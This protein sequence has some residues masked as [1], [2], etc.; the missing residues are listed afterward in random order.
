L[1][2][3]SFF[4]ECLLDSRHYTKFGMTSPKKKAHI[5][6]RAVTDYIGICFDGEHL[7]FV[8]NELKGTNRVTNLR[9]LDEYSASELAL[10][11][12]KDNRI[13]LTPQNVV[14]DFGPY[15]K[16][17]SL[18]L[19]ALWEDL[20]IALAKKIS[21]VDM[22][23]SEWNSL[24]EQSTSLGE[25]GQS[26]LNIYLTAIGLPPNVDSTRF[27]FVLHTYHALFF[28][29]LAAEVVLTNSPRDAQRG[30]IAE[31]ENSSLWNEGK[32]RENEINR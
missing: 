3:Q 1:L 13:E 31:Q 27:L 7:A 10:V 2:L 30:C 12:K 25:I 24:F 26:K 21:R 16:I 9:P 23:F 17:A 18:L 19:G 22:L 20:D 6:N 32:G 11:L 14:E 15:S 28:K 4:Y 29:L 8:F 5:D